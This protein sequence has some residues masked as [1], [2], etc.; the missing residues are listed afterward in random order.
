MLRLQSDGQVFAERTWDRDE[1]GLVRV[2]VPTVAAT[3]PAEHPAVILD[4]F[5]R[6]TDLHPAP[7]LLAWL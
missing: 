7:H 5:D 1:P 3:N 2:L 4:E 6:L